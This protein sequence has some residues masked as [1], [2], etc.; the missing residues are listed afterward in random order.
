MHHSKTYLSDWPCV[1]SSIWHGTFSIHDHDVFTSEDVFP[2]LN[3]Q[4]DTLCDV[5]KH[6]HEE[7]P[8]ALTFPVA[9]AQSLQFSHEALRQMAVRANVGKLYV[10]SGAHALFEG[11]YRSK[12]LPPWDAVHQSQHGRRSLPLAHFTLVGTCPLAIQHT[13]R[14]T[15]GTLTRQIGL[16]AGN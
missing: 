7:A 6:T 4:I 15:C 13:T 5:V 9:T 10:D 8:Q 2:S 14:L 1:V 3:C 11:S 12:A 16:S